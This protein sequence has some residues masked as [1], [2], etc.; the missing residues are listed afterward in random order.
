MHKRSIARS[1]LGIILCTA[2]LTG[3]G[4]S[5]T[6]VQ[7]EP[8]A[9][10]EESATVTEAATNEATDEPAQEETEPAAPADGETEPEPAAAETG[11]KRADRLLPGY[12][13]LYE[14]QDDGTLKKL[15]DVGEQEY[16]M[17][18][19]ASDKGAYV[20]TEKRKEAEGPDKLYYV[21]DQGMVHD[22]ELYRGKS[23]NT[24]QPHSFAV[25]EG[26]LVYHL[27]GDDPTIYAYD[28]E[29]G[30]ISDDLTLTGLQTKL[31]KLIDDTKWAL[32]YNMSAP[33]M[34][35]RSGCLMLTDN[36]GHLYR[37]DAEGK[38]IEIW[39]VLKPSAWYVPYDP[40]SVVGMDVEMRDYGNIVHGCLYDPEGHTIRSFTPQ[41]MDN[42]Y[43][44][45]VS[46]SRD[47]RYVYYQNQE[48]DTDKMLRT[49]YRIDTDNLEAG[50][51]EVFSVEP[52]PSFSEPYTTNESGVLLSPGRV[53][54]VDDDVYYLDY[55]DGEGFVW[56]TRPLN[57][58]A[59]AKPAGGTDSDLPY[60]AYGK[61]FRETDV[62]KN[63]E[64]GDKIYYTGEYEGF[65]LKG[66]YPGAEKINAGLQDMYHSFYEQGESMAESAENDFFGEDAD[67]YMSEIPGYSFT[68]SFSD[69]SEPVKNYL[70]IC[71]DGYEYY[72]G[73]HGMPFQVFCLFDTRT[74][75][76]KK[77]KDLFPGT[78]D[79][80]RDIVAD[81]TLEDWKK[82]GELYYES[83]TAGDE[84]Q[85]KT[86]RA[87][88]RESASFDMDVSFGKDGITVYYSPYAVGPYAAGFIP[89][90]IPYGALGFTLQ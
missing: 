26:R 43:G 31:G 50:E 25:C 35:E 68:F 12:Q 14:V 18:A 23:G 65:L 70:Q 82:D 36:D 33:A 37:Y 79:A 28:P 42:P 5:G 88:F 76:R 41:T 48:T 38:E 80:F 59:P 51:T 13:I 4:S 53:R 47:G 27:N 72:G 44:A 54:F 21:D 29:T 56:M 39:N 73:A 30:K 46:V 6:E 63:E 64:K 52:P 66:D 78:E 90:E 40:H 20:V 75:E 3:C 2:L 86:Q 89:V 83:Y 84:E 45:F 74:G 55:Q 87:T 34:L 32:V 22:T 58:S 9:N 24:F 62:R 11:M 15:L 61:V 77:I 10:P 71:F 69:V 19:D 16:I 57:G 1:L 81:Y 17:Y 49:L 60:A 8:A 67:E 7:P 85:E